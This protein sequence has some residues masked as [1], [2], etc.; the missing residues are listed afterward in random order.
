MFVRTSDLA[1]DL[2]ITMLTAVGKEFS[3]KS[4]SEE[5]INAY[6]LTMADMTCAYIDMQT[7][8]TLNGR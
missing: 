5:E 3:E 6:A 4:R 7:G 8:G 2:I 1:G